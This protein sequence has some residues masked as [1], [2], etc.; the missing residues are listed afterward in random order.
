[1]LS[2]A[3]ASVSWGPNRLDIFGLGTDNQMYHK[4]WDG[5]QWYPSPA[6]WE[7]LGGTFDNAPFKPAPK[8][9]SLHG[10]VDITFPDPTSVG[11][12]SDLTLNEDGSYKVGAH[13][14]D[15]G[16]PDYN[17]AVAWAVRD[18]TGVVYTFA[19]TGGVQGTQ[20]GFSPNRDWDWPS[21][22][23]GANPAIASAWS[24]IPPPGAAWVCK[25]TANFDV[26]ALLNEIV[27][28]IQKVVGIVVKVIAVVGPLVA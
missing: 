21:P 14:H 28:D 3:I 23:T 15:S 19:S 17:V 24:N 20:S 9:S 11:G 16:V 8:S 26:V 2:T 27:S 7:A 12:W 18:N 5:T 10:H 1:M 6:N 25:S 22:T 4:A 13:L